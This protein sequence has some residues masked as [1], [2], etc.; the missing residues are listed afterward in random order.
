M[1]IILL[2]HWQDVEANSN[3]AQS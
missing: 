3:S 1:I 2:A